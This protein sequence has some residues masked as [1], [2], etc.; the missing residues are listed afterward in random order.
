MVTKLR[1]F[2]TQR[3]SAFSVLALCD[4]DNENNNRGHFQEPKHRGLAEFL[5]KQARPCQTTPSY[6][7]EN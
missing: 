6:E 5:K 3:F 2:P 4:N 1:Q 7:D